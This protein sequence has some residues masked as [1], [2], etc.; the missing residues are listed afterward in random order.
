MK[1]ARPPGNH[2]LWEREWVTFEN[3]LRW[4]GLS[5]PAK[6][7]ILD[8]GCGN[9]GLEQGA[10]ARGFTYTGL[11]I[12]DADF[13]T[14]DLPLDDATIDVAFSLATLEHLFRP[15]HF[16]SEVRR[17]LKPG[18]LMLIT[19]PNIEFSGTAF[20]DNPGHNKP[21]TRKSL[22]KLLEISGFEVVV[23]YPGLRM[24]PRWMYE[25]R[26]RFRLAA[27]LPISKNIVSGPLVAISGRARSIAIVARNP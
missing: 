14:D 26:A 15:E 9:R 3:F 21:F 2:P 25:G 12:E 22:R 16:L 18:G 7:S 20:W 24:K 1:M 8:A 5:F 13:D 4:N 6:S 19:V 17:S 10:L 11:D 23:V 27:S